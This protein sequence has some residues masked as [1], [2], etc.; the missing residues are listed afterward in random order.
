M[1]GHDR[2]LLA[3]IIPLLPF[4]KHRSDFFLDIVF[5]TKLITRVNKGFVVSWLLFHIFAISVA[6]PSHAILFLA[7]SSIFI[8]R[9]EF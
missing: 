6:N 8:L 9:P 2:C 4:M 1:H 7:N 5:L 3:D